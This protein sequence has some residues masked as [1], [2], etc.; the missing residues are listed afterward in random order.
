MQL[1]VLDF[2]EEIS[3]K[4][5][6]DPVLIDGKTATPLDVNAIFG[7]GNQFAGSRGSVPGSR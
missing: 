4:L 2:P 1:A 7:I 5:E 6:I 3:A